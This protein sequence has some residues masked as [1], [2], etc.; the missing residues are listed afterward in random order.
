MLKQSCMTAPSFQPCNL[1][2]PHI[3]GVGP[4]S[5]RS[6]TTTELMVRLQQGDVQ[7]LVG[8]QGCSGETGNPAT[9]H[10]HVLD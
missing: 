5:E 6:S 3:K 8:Q 4:P 9:D 2:R 10:D 1:S 7:I